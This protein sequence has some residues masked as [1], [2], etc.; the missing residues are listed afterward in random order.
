MENRQP[1]PP[2]PAEFS[3]R[4]TKV[5][6]WLGA[7][8]LAMTLV[9]LAVL[10]RQYFAY[11]TYKIQTLGQYAQNYPWAAE[12]PGVEA[13]VDMTLSWVVECPGLPTL[14]EGQLHRLMQECWHVATNT[15]EYCA[16]VGDSYRATSFGYPECAQRKARFA[17]QGKFMKSKLCN[18][19]YRIIAQGCAEMLATQE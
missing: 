16:A 5:L 15:G 9:I 19:N 4:P 8:V 17:S 10:G 7:M 1:S 11:R 13:C 2:A 18:A 6:W 14:C 3:P 12:K